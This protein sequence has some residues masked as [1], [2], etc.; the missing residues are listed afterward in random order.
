M[1][2]VWHLSSPQTFHFGLTGDWAILCTLARSLAPDESAP[3][4]PAH[5]YPAPASKPAPFL[6]PPSVITLTRATTMTDELVAKKTKKNTSPSVSGWT[7]RPI[8]AIFF[9]LSKSA[10]K[11]KD[12]LHTGHTFKRLRETQWVRIA[13]KQILSTSVDF[14]RQS[15]GRDYLGSREAALHSAQQKGPKEL[16]LIAF[17]FVFTG[18]PEHLFLF[19]YAKRGVNMALSTGSW[20]WTV[21]S[22]AAS[23]FLCL[24]F[25]IWHVRS[26]AALAQIY[27]FLFS[28]FFY[29]GLKGK[30]AF[31]DTYFMLNLSAFMCRSGKTLFWRLSNST[32]TLAPVV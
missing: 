17:M 30:F 13:E 1:R 11:K 21:L 26:T 27:V 12:R 14:K 22:T 9:V 28:F 25:R 5:F 18:N 32:P 20:N 7:K 24:R 6:R 2:W 31:H 16:S 23:P 3:A 29:K 15:D 8:C 4:P 10:K 19:F